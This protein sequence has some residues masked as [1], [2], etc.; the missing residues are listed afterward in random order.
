MASYAKS[1]EKVRAIAKDTL[2][3]QSAN[4]AKTV[5]LLA[6]HVWKDGKPPEI[7]I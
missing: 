6:T 3:I 1:I 5:T 2:Q 4:N 7:K